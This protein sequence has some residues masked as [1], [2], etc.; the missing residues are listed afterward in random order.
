[1]KAFVQPDR[2]GSN[3][4]NETRNNGKVMGSTPVRRLDYSLRRHFVDQF[5][6]KQV[7]LLNPGSMVLD[8]GGNRISKRGVFNMDQYDL[9][10]IYA[11]LS[12]EKSP[13]VQTDAQAMPFGDRSFDAAICSEVLEHVPDPRAVLTEI[14]RVLKPGGRLIGCVPFMNRMHGDP[15]DFGRYSDWFLQRTLEEIGF[16]EVATERQGHFWSVLADTLRDAAY[17]ESIAGRGGGRTRQRIVSWAM[18]HFKELALKWDGRTA[19]G[20]TG[21]RSNYTTGFGFTGMRP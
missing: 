21:W 7:P 20:D 14:L 19:N 2:R 4:K 1:M 10:V 6:L 12:A 3:R 18:G 9:T 17:S 13:H 11:N 16:V 8:V 5:H 15:Y